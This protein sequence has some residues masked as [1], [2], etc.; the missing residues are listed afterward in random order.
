MSA[1]MSALGS[2]GSMLLDGIDWEAVFVDDESGDGTAE[3]LAGR[4]SAP[5]GVYAASTDWAPARFEF[6]LHREHLIELGA[7]H[8]GYRR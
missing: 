4:A 2:N 5:I 8:R 1:T 3:H 6:G 7:L